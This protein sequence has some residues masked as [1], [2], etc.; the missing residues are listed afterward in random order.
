[1]TAL[2]LL[3]AEEWDADCQGARGA[4]ARGYE[5][6]R[7]PAF[8]RLSEHRG[9]RSRRVFTTSCVLSVHKARGDLDLRSSETERVP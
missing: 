4:G 1:M 2:P 6:V 9:S 3:I 5:D 8:R 7:Q